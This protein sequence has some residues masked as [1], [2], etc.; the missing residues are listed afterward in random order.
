MFVSDLRHFLDISDEAPGPARRMAEHLGFIVR[1]ATAREAGSRWVSA[2]LCRRRPANRPCGG[3][4]AVFRTDLPAT[5]QW[6][7]TGCNDEGVISGWEDSPYDLRQSLA[8]S[9]NELRYETLVNDEL[10]ETLRRL[11]LLDMEC[12]RLVFQMHSSNEGIVLTAS[13]EELDDLLGF[14]AADANHETNRRRQKRLDAALDVL[15]DALKD[16]E[17]ALIL[18]PATTLTGPTSDTYRD[19]GDLMGRWRIL[20]MDLWDREALDLVAP[21]FIEFS[22]DHTGRFGFIVVTGWIDWRSAG[23]HRTGIEFSWE[24]TDEG[25]QVSGRGWAA[26]QDGLLLGHLYFHLGDDSNFRAGR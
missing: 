16:V 5:I 23:T 7:C 14:V 24:G 12:E 13:V 15:S 6:R 1:A 11:M 4:I 8:V 10:A 18:S 9:D 25:D 19:T 26:L 2:L 20:E 22:P 17:S 21:A 3:H